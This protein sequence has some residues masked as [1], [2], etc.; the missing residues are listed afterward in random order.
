M[1][2]NSEGSKTRLSGVIE[3]EVGLVFS[4]VDWAS[5]GNM[6]RFLVGLILSVRTVS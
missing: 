6:Q 1:R 3:S 5:G 4:E 2:R